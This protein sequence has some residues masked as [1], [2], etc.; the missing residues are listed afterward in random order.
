M[1]CDTGVIQP[2][3]P[4][5]T[6]GLRGTAH[7]ELQ[8]HGPK[9]DLHS[10][11]YGGVVLNPL[12]ALTSIVASLYNKDGSVAVPGF[13]DHVKPVSDEDKKLAN[14]APINVGDMQEMLG[15]S[16]AGGERGVP[17]ME[18]R[19]FRPTLE[20]N[21]I[22]GGYQGAGGKTVI[23]SHAFA[24]FSMRL[25]KGQEPQE[26]FDIVVRHLEQMRVEGVRIEVHD[27]VVSGPALS[28]SSLSPVIKKA[29]EAIVKAFGQE[30]VYL[31]EGASIPIVAKLAVVSGADPLLV[32]FGEEGDKIH[33]PDE[34]FS[35]RQLQE[36]FRYVTSFFSVV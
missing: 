33:A 36:G 32:G 31:W 12:Q 19:G 28:I 27:K 11:V 15:V 18:R 2:S 1:V 29:R 13:Y 24:K 30:P 5:I 26:T 16:L 14:S 4:T 23:P 22:G 17:V 21:G 10:G 9:Y 25:V 3:Q 35:L 7:F 6:M 8:V 20:L 34:S